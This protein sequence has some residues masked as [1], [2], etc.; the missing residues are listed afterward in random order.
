MPTTKIALDSDALGDLK[1]RD[2]TS[3][4]L[5]VAVAR[6]LADWPVFSPSRRVDGHDPHPTERFTADCAV[7]CLAMFLGVEYEDVLRHVGGHELTLRGLTNY[8]EAYIARLF[9]VDIS[10]LDRTKID[11]SKPAVLTV[12]S[13]NSKTGLTHA[14]YWDGTRIYDPNQGC[15]ARRPTRA[16]QRGKSLSM[17]TSGSPE[18]R[19]KPRTL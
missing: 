3:L 4:D 10:F 7:A 14:V 5:F 6:A 18:G 13:L 1:R 9:E 17:A 15:K 12:P 16:K 2:D 19:C 8:R 11:R